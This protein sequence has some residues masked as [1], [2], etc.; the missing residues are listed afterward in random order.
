MVPTQRK[1]RL[2]ILDD[3]TDLQGFL[4]LL[5]HEEYELTMCRNGAELHTRVAAG[6]ADIILLDIGLPEEDGIAIAQRIRAISDIPLVFLSGFTTADIIVKGLS[7]GGY[8][9]ITKP[10]QSEV[11]QARIRNALL[12][13]RPTEQRRTS[14]QRANKA[15]ISFDLRQQ[16]LTCEVGRHVKLTWLE[17]QI[18]SSLA[19][20]D[21]RTLSRNE[22][23][24]RMHGRDWE[25]ID[26]SLEVHIY[27]LRKK[28][29]RA[30]S[31]ENPISSIRG[32]GY[33]LNVD[34]KE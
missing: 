28:L 3:D 14:A 9:Y 5:L 22:I 17:A 27:N 23:S 7:I 29:C 30:G 1:D 32:I 21:K 34:L 4:H 13:S 19:S 18:L 2:A 31:T 25:P 33:R 10:F 16:R 12:L 8:D 26:R 15:A 20:A 24:R 11:L 6:Q